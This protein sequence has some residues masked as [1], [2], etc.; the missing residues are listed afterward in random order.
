MKNIIFMPFINDVNHGQEWRKKCERD[1][2]S[3]DGNEL[4]RKINDIR[5]KKSDTE[6]YADENAY[7]AALH[8]KKRERQQMW[9]KYLIN[10]TARVFVGKLDDVKRNNANADAATVVCALPE[11]FWCDI[12]DNDKHIS[13]IDGYHKP[14][15]LETLE[16]VLKK[17][18]KLT[19]LT[20]TYPN[21]IFFA[22]TAMWKKIKENDNEEEKIFNTLITYAEGEYKETITKHN[23]SFIDGFYDENQCLIK[24]K[25]GNGES[26]GNPVT[27]FNGLDF[28]YDICLD[29]MHRANQNDYNEQ[30]RPLSTKLCLKNG[31]INNDVNV[32]IA[33]GMPVDGEYIEENT[34]SSVFLRCDGLCEP[35]GQALI[36]SCGSDGAAVELIEI[37]PQ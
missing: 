2:L 29:F 32:L 13:D 22:G 3:G 25:V 35:Y 24:N 20:D 19:E 7:Y 4:T 30:P 26:D 17:Q 6:A 1:F 16:N 21:M 36:R 37:N 10:E 11:F 18:N 28:T 33:A 15:Y 8:E 27:K 5:G 12:N 34:F 9:V 31:I 23:V 14:L